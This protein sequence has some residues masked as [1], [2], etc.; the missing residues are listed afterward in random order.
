MGHLCGDNRFLLITLVEIA[1]V[2]SLV[3]SEERG[4]R[5]K[6]NLLQ[7]ELVLGNADCF[8][9]LLIPYLPMEGFFQSLSLGLK[10]N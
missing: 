7:S 6:Q 4:L 3:L 1:H 10:L 8:E 2:L 9:L 5:S